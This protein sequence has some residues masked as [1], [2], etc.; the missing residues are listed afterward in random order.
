MHNY[1]KCVLNAEEARDRYFNLEEY[2]YSMS[3][4]YSNT[5]ISLIFDCCRERM[6]IES[7]RG[8]YGGDEEV[9]DSK[10]PF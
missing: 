5:F 8:G 1:T 2:I 10:A 3:S 9:L 7:T 6:A 4:N